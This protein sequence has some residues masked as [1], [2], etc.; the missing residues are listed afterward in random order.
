MLA[1]I[2]AMNTVLVPSRAAE[3][4]SIDTVDPESGTVELDNQT[5]YHTEEPIDTWN[6]GNTVLVPSRYSTSAAA[7]HATHRMF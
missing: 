2:S 1:Y 6:T 5:T 4:H 7:S 3:E